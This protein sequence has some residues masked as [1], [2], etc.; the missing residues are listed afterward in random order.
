MDYGRED[1][2][3]GKRGSLLLQFRRPVDRLRQLAQRDRE[4]P[5]DPECE[6]HENVTDYIVSQTV[7]DPDPGR[8]SRSG[9]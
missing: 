4:P 9:R 5:A 1:K 6:R 8:P 7:Y 2:V 3:A